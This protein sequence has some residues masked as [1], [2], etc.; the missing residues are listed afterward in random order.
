[1]SRLKSRYAAQD[2]SSGSVFDEKQ[3]SNGVAVD[4]PALSS[5]NMTPSFSSPGQRILL[6]LFSN[7]AYK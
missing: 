2:E 1:M 5:S 7:T 4:G 3:S 6:S